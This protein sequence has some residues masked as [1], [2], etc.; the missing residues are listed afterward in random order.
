MD[1]EI[2]E[3]VV[4]PA[5]YKEAFKMA[6]ESYDRPSAYRS[7]YIVRKYKDLGGQYKDVKHIG[8]SS[9]LRAAGGATKSCSNHST[10]RSP[11]FA[12][13]PNPSTGRNEEN[14][15][16]RS[17]SRCSRLSPSSHRLTLF[18]RTRRRETWVSVGGWTLTLACTIAIF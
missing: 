8:C 17:R 7:M 11:L 5:L 14:A 3:N 12:H 9:F 2:P 16:A 10:S 4:N 6:Q 18:L 1:I 13:F 15:R